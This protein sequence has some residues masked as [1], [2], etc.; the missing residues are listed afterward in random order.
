MNPAI[1]PLTLFYDA[2][3]PLCAAEMHN[4]MLRNTAGHLAFVDVSAPEVPSHIDGVSREAMMTEIHARQADGEW[5]RGVDVFRLAYQA[6][7]LPQVSKVLS[8]PLLAPMAD[9]LYPWVARNRQHMPQVLS[10]LLFGRALR[11]AAAQVQARQCAAGAC[12]ATPNT[13]SEQAS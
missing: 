4:L 10:G 2:S 7:G 5:V 12:S 9:A 3:C 13:S 6:A 11:R 1:Y 8:W